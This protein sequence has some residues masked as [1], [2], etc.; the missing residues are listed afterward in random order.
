[1]LNYIGLIQVICFAIQDIV[2][3][4]LVV[5]FPTYKARVQSLRLFIIVLEV[6][7]GCLLDDCCCHGDGEQ[8]LCVRIIR[9]PI[10]LQNAWFT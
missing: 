10:L 8:V 4:I 3:Y 7:G 9:Y 6:I 2:R 5:V 1:M